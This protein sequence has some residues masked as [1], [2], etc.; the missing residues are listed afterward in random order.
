MKKFFDSK[1]GLLICGLFI[2]G[3]S[4]VLAILGNPGNM[5]FCVACFIR[6]IAGA[7]KLHTN[8]V[9]Q[10]YRPEIVGLVVGAFIISIIFGEF[11]VKSGSS[12]FTRFLLGCCTMIMA[13]IFLGCPLRMVLR[14]SSGDLNAYI[15]FIGFVL[16]IILGTVFLKNGYE[17]SNSY[18]EDKKFS[19][20]IL[21]F[22]LVVG[23]IILATELPQIVNDIGNIQF[24]D[25]VKT[26]F[27]YSS[28]GPGSFHAPILISLI[29]GAVVGAIAQKSR[30]CFAG[31][32]RNI[33]FTKKFDLIFVIV[34]IFVSMTIYNIIT[35][36]F[37]FSFDGH[38]VAHKAHLWNF[39]SMFG[40]GLA[41]TLAGGCP[42]RQLILAGQGSIDNV[43]NVIGMLF[44][45]AIS[46][47]FGLAGAAYAKN[48]LDVW[49]VGG[50]APA[51]Q[52][53]CIV[54]IVIVVVIGLLNIQYNIKKK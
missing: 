17:L 4:I 53:A 50:P 7:L 34:G 23:F 38:P 49:I 35:G 19:G 44:G 45:A 29:I 21:P 28:A 3:F 11:K 22:F 14:M 43:F 27:G 16:G 26:L 47:N 42:L 12:P 30:T 8:N 39:L 5:A 36:N 10:Y 25:S 20:F 2:G 41:A 32:I 31:S 46:H 18:E 51:G 37:Y 24:V 33:I 1:Y 48:M 6:D 54:C 13:L 15:G 40:V 9:V 52:I